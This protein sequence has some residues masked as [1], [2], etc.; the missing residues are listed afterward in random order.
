MATVTEHRKRGPGLGTVDTEDN[1]MVEKSTETSVTNRKEW[2]RQL[3][4]WDS[5]WFHGRT[6]STPWVG[7]MAKLVVF[8]Q[9]TCL[10]SVFSKR[11]QKAS[12]IISINYFL[13]PINNLLSIKMLSGL[14]I[15]LFF[16]NRNLLS[17]KL[18]N[19]DR[20]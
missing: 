11:S 8:Y 19:I 5:C 15:E 17:P 18:L 20:N 9:P 1:L 7:D 13:V 2:W 3:L 16:A 4:S 6:G 12:S 14:Q 10:K